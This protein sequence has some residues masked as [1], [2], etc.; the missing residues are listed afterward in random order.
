MSL[1]SRLRVT[2]RRFGEDRRGSMPT[3]GVIA[4]TF[5]IWWY[6]AS[7]QIF[8][9]YKQK[10]I[11]LKAAYTVADLISRVPAEESVDEAYINGLNTLFDYLTFS[12][13]PTWLRVS[14]V[15]WNDDTGQYNVG[16]SLA[17]GAAIGYDNVTIQNQAYRIP[18]LAT[19][20][21]IIIVESNMAYEPIFNIGIN[22]QWYTTFIPTRPRFASCVRYDRHDGSNPACIYDTAIDSSDNSHTDG[23]SD[24]TVA[25]DSS[26]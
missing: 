22:A 8:D 7:F 14:S 15:F 2:V 19:G 3:E 23:T 11:N 10:N 13:V 1:L 18:I 24:P 9:A 26:S 6:A 5:L 17:T 12:R 4:A 20:D 25:S 21:Y 16:W